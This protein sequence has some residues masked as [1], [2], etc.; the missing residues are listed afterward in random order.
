[1]K[2]EKDILP[3]RGWTVESLKNSTRKQ[4]H[5]D[6]LIV[7]LHLVLSLQLRFTNLNIPLLNLIRL[8]Q[9]CM[10][11]WVIMEWGVTIVQVPNFYV[12]SLSFYCIMLLPVKGGELLKAMK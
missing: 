11:V 10:C 7:F 1:M 4:V 3:M 5:C 2:D 9:L 12:S 8:T 6:K